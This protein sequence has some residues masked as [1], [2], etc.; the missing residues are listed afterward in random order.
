MPVA[1]LSPPVGFD[2]L[3]AYERG[4]LTFDETV[5]LFQSLL[6]S[7]GLHRLQPYYVRTALALLDSGHCIV[8]ASETGG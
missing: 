7:G 2:E 1:L 5:D 8:S 6:D 3:V 4:D